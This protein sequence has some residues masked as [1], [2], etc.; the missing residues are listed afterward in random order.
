MR[1]R[2][3]VFDIRSSATQTEYLG[4][5][6]SN[7]PLSTNKFVNI[8]DARTSSVSFP[9][10]ILTANQHFGSLFVLE[11]LSLNVAILDVDFE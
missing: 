10:Y 9:I 4:N 8:V 2:V 11:F 1:D 5:A 6:K 7:R 3:N